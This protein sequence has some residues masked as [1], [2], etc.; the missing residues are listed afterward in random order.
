MLESWDL[1]FRIAP[2][3]SLSFLSDSKVSNGSTALPTVYKQGIP[4]FCSV[5]SP[6]RLL[7]TWKL[8]TQL[9]LRQDGNGWLGIRVQ[10]EGNLGSGVNESAILSFHSSFDLPMSTHTFAPIHHPLGALTVTCTYLSPPAFMI[11]GLVS[12]PS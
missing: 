7:P 1:N 4:F 9:K 3:P 6:L 8:S 2:S 10:V 12:L 5:Y 11:D